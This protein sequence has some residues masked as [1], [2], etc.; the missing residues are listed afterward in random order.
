RRRA[1]RKLEWNPGEESHGEVKD[2]KSASALASSSSPGTAA[3]AAPSETVP[4]E[5]VSPSPSPARK[6]LRFAPPTPPRFQ[7][8]TPFKCYVASPDSDPKKSV[9]LEEGDFVS[10]WNSDNH[11]VKYQGTISRFRMKYSTCEAQMKVAWI[12]TYED[13]LKLYKDDPKQQKRMKQVLSDNHFEDGDIATSAHISGWLDMSKHFVSKD[14]PIETDFTMR[15][16][17]DTKELVLFRVSDDDRKIGEEHRLTVEESQLR[18]FLC[19]HS[20]LTAHTT[21][22]QLWNAVLVR[23]RMSITPD[24]KFWDEKYP[25]YSDTRLEFS[26]SEIKLTAVCDM[27]HRHKPLTHS[28]IASDHLVSWTGSVDNGC[29]HGLHRLYV[30]HALTRDLGKWYRSYMKDRKFSQVDHAMV[31]ETIRNGYAKFHKLMFE[32]GEIK[33]TRIEYKV[34]KDVE[35]VTDKEVEFFR[36][37]Y[38]REKKDKE[39]EAKMTHAVHSAWSSV[40]DGED[41]D[42]DADDGQ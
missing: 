22:G 42:A 31:V 41:V 10:I 21:F 24:T 28:V 9:V 12:Y 14:E 37:W 40:W 5:P 35:D 38:Q 27:C 11:T 26:S 25:H 15:P 2:Q 3:A 19:S 39:E 23:I 20:Y 16:D 7:L 13:I 36:G 18:D 33:K 8:L 4:P 34:D 1:K 29:Y 30:L 17:T 32:A 6:R